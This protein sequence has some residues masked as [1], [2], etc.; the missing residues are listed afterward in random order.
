MRTE[1]AG[2]LFLLSFRGGREEAEYLKPGSR[3]CS[4]F[5]LYLFLF[6]NSPNSYL[7][8]FFFVNLSISGRHLEANTIGPFN[9]IILFV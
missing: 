8:N 4:V 3:M 2:N 1:T 5:F 7:S 9:M 6:L